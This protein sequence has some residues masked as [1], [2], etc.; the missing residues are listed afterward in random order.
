MKIIPLH[1]NV[2]ITEVK[3]EN[4]TYGGIIVESDKLGESRTGLVI[5]VGPEVS[6]VTPGDEVLVNWVH[7]Q[8]VIV[9][10]KQH[11]LIDAEFITAII[12]R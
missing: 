3:R 12:Q 1:K 11:V 5:D 4:K 2:L 8:I 6:E 10:G 7:G 9:G